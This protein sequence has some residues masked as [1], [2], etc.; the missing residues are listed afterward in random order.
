M[1]MN[2]NMMCALSLNQSGFQDYSLE[3]HD[4]FATDTG[5]P[6]HSAVDV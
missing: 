2:M 1:L 3:H 5:C 6:V 4:Q